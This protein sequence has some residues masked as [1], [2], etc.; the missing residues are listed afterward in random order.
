MKKSYN[1]YVCTK[2]HG[3]QKNMND[4]LF[5]FIREKLFS[6]CT[7]FILSL[8]CL[9]SVPALASEHRPPS[10][11]H[12][13][14][15]AGTISLHTGEVIT[16]HSRIHTKTLISASA[17]DS[18]SMCDKNN[19]YR[20]IWYDKNQKIVES[21]PWQ[22]IQWTPDKDAPKGPYLRI[23]CRRKDRGRI[24]NIRSVADSLLIRRT[25]NEK[26]NLRQGTAVSLNWE[27]GDYSKEEKNMGDYVRSSSRAR[28]TMPIYVGE[29]LTISC[30]N[31]VL[32]FSLVY[33]DNNLEV[34]SVSDWFEPSSI[35]VENAHGFVLLSVRYKDNRIMTDKRLSIIRNSIQVFRRG[36][37]ISQPKLK[38]SAIQ[39]PG[40]DGDASNAEK[41]L[42]DTAEPR[43]VPDSAV[44]AQ[45][46]KY[47]T[48]TAVKYQRNKGD[49]PYTAA[50]LFRT[51]SAPF[52]FYWADGQ[53]DRL[54][55]L[56]TWDSSLTETDGGYQPIDYSCTITAE[57]D[58]LF[59]FR[60]EKAQYDLSYIR[61]DASEVMDQSI[62]RKD[63]IIYPHDDYT[64]PKVIRFPKGTAPT[65]WLM[66]NGTLAEDGRLFV[67]EYTRCSFD[68]SYLW[69]AVAPYDS[70][71]NWSRLMAFDVGYPVNE[72]GESNRDG[73]WSISNDFK[74]FHNIDR[75][76][77]SGILYTSIG[78][79]DNAA[80]IFYSA[81]DGVTW[82]PLVAN[83]EA[84]SRQMNFIWQ[85]DAVYWATDSGNLGKHFLFMATRDQ[86]GI[87][88]P[89]SIQKLYRF[90]T[91]TA[92][93]QLCYLRE[94]EALLAL[95]RYDGRMSSGPLNVYY[96]NLS[97]HKM[98]LIRRILSAQENTFLGFR[99]EA[100]TAW[101]GAS[102]D[103]IVCGFS[104]FPNQMA[105]LGNP[106]NPYFLTDNGSV[107]AEYGDESNISCVNNLMI[108]VIQ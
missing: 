63:P 59:V 19:E 60:G 8:C 91:H 49:T 106:G 33:L 93:Y 101:Q 72:K 81:D 94:P 44:S 47:L 31:S 18:V 43:Q 86:T 71:E 45:Y 73:E 100:I 57:N 16:S 66:S 67:A 103:C 25:K 64:K 30:S 107:L 23:V 36:Q 51:N 69:Q 89:D 68:K 37:N 56:F 108:R 48:L 105:V 61:Q 38:F 40:D 46:Q 95:E 13:D 22:N 90:Y 62:L 53:P 54:S 78:D 76:P 29:D 3:R 77:Y 50:Y 14:F 26:I 39:N 28:A 52:K 41:R 85:P 42:P 79:R 11:Y 17:I 104:Y 55:Y 4:R 75:D 1:L 65:S 96:F 9:L 70:S 87:I 35:T 12:P 15:T 84:I 102:D 32:Q 92:T 10:Y 27:I 6:A 2:D 88:S 74:H 24:N 20:I 80:S 98:R 97:T 5:S 21:T 99:C 83:N 34:V 7:V 82:K 58:I